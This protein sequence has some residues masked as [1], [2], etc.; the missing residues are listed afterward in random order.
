MTRDEIIRD[1]SGPFLE[2]GHLWKQAFPNI[3]FSSHAAIEWLV[4]EEGFSPSEA[5]KVP[6]GD[7]VKLLERKL[8]IQPRCVVQLDELKAT[9]LGIQQADLTGGQSKVVRALIEAGSVGLSGAQ[10]KSKSESEDAVKT[11]RRI[12]RKNDE[13]RDAIIFPGKAYGGYHL[14]HR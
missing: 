5:D 9:I 7:F 11:L 3:E 13:W 10:L 1:I 4:A 14:K 8:G 2:I 6:I 12:A